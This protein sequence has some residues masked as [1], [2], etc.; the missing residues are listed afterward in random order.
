MEEHGKE[1]ATLHYTTEQIHV[2]QSLFING[3]SV[4][5]LIYI[6]FHA[7]DVMLDTQS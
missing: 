5:F 3:M 4:F 7:A 6:V 1:E 2:R